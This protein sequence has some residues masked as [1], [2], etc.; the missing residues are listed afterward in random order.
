MR[1]ARLFMQG[2]EFDQ[3][4]L[5]PIYVPICPHFAILLQLGNMDSGLKVLNQATRKAN[6][7]QPN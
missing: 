5:D 1:L 7:S 4:T 6:E 3:E 2:Y